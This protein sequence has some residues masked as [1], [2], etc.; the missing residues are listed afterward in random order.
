MWIQYALFS[1]FLWAI[2]HVLDEH[3][4]DNI[5]SKP[6]LG[7]VTSSGIS[8]GIFLL[9]P[10]LNIPIVIPHWD[11]L[12]LC[13]TTGAIIQLS[14]YFYFRALDGSDSGTVS[15]YWNLTP[16]FLVIISYWLFGYFITGNNYI[17]IAL[18]IIASIGLCSI[19]NF[20]GR[21][22]TLY[23]MS[24]ASGLLTIV[25]TI[26]KYIFDRTDFFG[27]F[28]SITAGMI[29]SGLACLAIPAVRSTL[30]RDFSKIEQALP[31]FFA[32][33]LLNLAA[34]YTGQLAVKLGV[35]VLVSAIEASTPAYAFGLSLLIAIFRR[36]LD[37]PTERLHQRETNRK[38]PLKWGFVSL[39]IMGVWLLG[40]TG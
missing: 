17:G 9:L 2:V 37:S 1:S 38:L 16:I 32:I 20:S 5:F 18:L 3:C 33:E 19:D 34:L 25:M 26:E 7:V 6:W 11:L 29:I 28:L 14:Q 36:R 4:V 27:A 13:L 40:A 8:A 15:A 24:V 30:V 23:L 31:I 10:L 21:W 22:H 12:A 39:M 35:P